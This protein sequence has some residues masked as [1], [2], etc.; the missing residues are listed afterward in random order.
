ML[1]I[2]GH[3]P[4]IPLCFLR[5]RMRS[6]AVNRRPVATNSP[7][8]SRRCVC[9]RDKEKIYYCLSYCQIYSNLQKA[10]DVY[11]FVCVWGTCFVVSSCL[12]GVPVVL[13]SGVTPDSEN[14]TLSSSGAIDQSS[15]TG[16]PLS[17]TITSPEG[18]HTHT[19]TFVFLHVP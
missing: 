9:D 10:V 6:L 4:R 8:T 7:W 14:L 16:T 2:L 17:S 18:T 5:R 3:F 11:M 13:Q 15:C 1:F 19:Y 12:T